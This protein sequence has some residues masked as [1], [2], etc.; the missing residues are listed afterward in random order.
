M[1]QE[2]R[3]KFLIDYLLK[4][5]KQLIRYPLYH[6]DTYRSLVNTREPMVIDEDY[7][8]IEDDYLQNLN[9][10]II[11]VSCFDK[12]ITLWKGDITTL[13]ADV[14]VNAANSQML[15]CFIPHHHCIDNAIHTYAGIRLRLACHELMIKQGC[16]EKTG[17]AKITEAY[18]LPSQFVIHTVGPI[19]QGV[20]L[21]EHRLLLKNCYKKCLEL[22][23]NNQCQSIVFCAISTGVFRF[24]KKEAAGIAIHTVSEFLKEHD[25]KIIFNVF[26]EEDESIYQQIL[27]EEAWKQTNY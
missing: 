8:R 13:K 22:A 14:I 23:V 19:V 6:F 26:S 4:E 7:L 5:R 12:Q 16:E 2:K 1:N 18:N 25:L 27:E 17:E 11:D 10:E 21:D 9:R 24:P 20:L 15:G 3:E